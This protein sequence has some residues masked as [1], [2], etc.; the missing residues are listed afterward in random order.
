MENLP[1]DIIRNI[2]AYFNLGELASLGRSSK[3]CYK[4]ATDP[5]LPQWKSLELYLYRK[6][7]RI[8]SNCKL[9]TR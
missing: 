3:T 5:A 9:R 1:T 4:F 6:T 7:V 2:F 8:A